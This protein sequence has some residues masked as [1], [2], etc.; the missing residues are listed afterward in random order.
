MAIGMVGLDLTFLHKIGRRRMKRFDLTNKNVKEMID[1]YHVI[2]QKVDAHTMFIKKLEQNMNQLSTKVNPHH[3]STLLSNSI[4]NMKNY[5][6]CME[7]TTQG[8]KQTIDTPLLSEVEI[9]VRKDDDEIQV[10]PEYKNATEKKVEITKKVVHMPRPPP[11][12]LQRLV[13]KN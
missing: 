8:G 7:V 12:F 11:P 13:Q 10:T 9:I 4:K 2:S 6:H 3:P 5:G 1:N